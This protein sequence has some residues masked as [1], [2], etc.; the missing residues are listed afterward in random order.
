[1]SKL[2]EVRRHGFLVTLV[3]G[4]VEVE[5]PENMQETPALHDRLKEIK[6]QLLDELQAEANMALRASQGAT[7]FT[8]TYLCYST[9]SDKNGAGRII[10]EFR[11]NDT[12]EIV[13]AFFNAHLTHQ[14]GQSKGTRFRTGPGCRFWITRSSKFGKLWF[15]AFGEPDRWTNLYRRMGPLKSI[16][17]TGTLRSKV[18]HS[19]CQYAQ[20]SDLA[21]MGS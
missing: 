17:F 4:S 5:L 14:R 15:D 6:P 8:Y 7:G 1:M 3:E 16:R 13:V 18:N 2:A 19:G 12:G 20:L 21:V 10:L 9:H 11:C